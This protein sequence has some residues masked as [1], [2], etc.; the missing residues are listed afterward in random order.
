[1]GRHTHQNTPPET[2]GSADI[3]RQFGALRDVAST[4]SG[5]EGKWKGSQ[6]LGQ[7][8]NRVTKCERERKRE[9]ERER[10]KRGRA[11]GRERGREV[12]VKDRDRGEQK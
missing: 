12:M 7:V 1:M 9:R 3:Y 10:E 5:R 2:E 4:V 8:S 11:R 6:R